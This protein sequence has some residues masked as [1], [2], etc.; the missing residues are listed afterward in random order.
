MERPAT[1]M[2]WLETRYHRPN[3][4]LNQP[5][6]LEAAAKMARVNLAVAYIAAQA[7]ERPRW[8]EGDF[9]AKFG[10]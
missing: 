2:R 5:L 9:F 3:D 4:D 10:R 6:N 7:P 1:V 8:N